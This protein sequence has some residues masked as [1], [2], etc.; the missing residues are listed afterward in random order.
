[1]N[2]DAK[3]Q[4]NKALETGKIEMGSNKTMNSLLNG[5]PKMVILTSNCPKSRKETITYYCQLA[6]VSCV[7]IKE[8]SIELG[9]GCGRPHPIS[10]V[11]ILDEGESTILE[12]RA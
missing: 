9:S 3:T 8:T 7:T 10:A 2:V 1:V 4:I 5:K 12:A 6:G 11:A